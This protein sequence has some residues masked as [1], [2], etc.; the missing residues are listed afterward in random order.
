[1]ERL[2][3]AHLPPGT[4]LEFRSFRVSPWTTF[5]PAFALQ[6]L[7]VP[8]VVYPFEICMYHWR[9]DPFTPAGFGAAGM[10]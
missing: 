7:R 3:A 9:P 5:P 8:R 4:A 6:W 1:L 10:R 2:A